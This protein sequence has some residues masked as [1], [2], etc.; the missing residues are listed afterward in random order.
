ML[1]QWEDDF[2]ANDM[3]TPITLKCVFAPR[4]FGNSKIEKEN[5]Q[6]FN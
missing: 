1:N 5:T 6:Q 4:E 2:A 3:T